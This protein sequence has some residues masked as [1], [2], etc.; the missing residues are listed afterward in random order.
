MRY[1]ERF[2]VMILDEYDDG[3]WR[4]WWGVVDGEAGGII[5]T[6]PDKDDAVV[7]RDFYRAR[8]NA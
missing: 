3:R 1:T 2:W 7:L 4:G 8:S 6:A 5:A